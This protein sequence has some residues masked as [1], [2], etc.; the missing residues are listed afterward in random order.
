MRKGGVR[1]TRCRW[2]WF[3]LAALLLLPGL[4]LAQ[5]PRGLTLQDAQSTGNG[6]ALEVTGYSLVGLTII[7]SSGADRVVNWEATQDG[8]NYV[9]ISCQNRNSL[10]IAT[11]A[12]AT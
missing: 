7:G 1:V 5:G 8:T 9:A 10:A 6:T 3:L 2:V 11:T 4:A 12:T